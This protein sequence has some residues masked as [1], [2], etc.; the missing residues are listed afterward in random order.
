VLKIL[1]ITSGGFNYTPCAIIFVLFVLLYD[2]L[3][4]VAEAFETCRRMVNY[5]KTFYSCAFCVWLQRYKQ[6]SSV[7][8]DVN[9]GLIDS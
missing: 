5:D 1:T 6:R 9:I 7:Y 4:M 2:A 8:W 3:M